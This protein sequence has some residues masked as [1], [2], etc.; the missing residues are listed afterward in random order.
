MANDIDQVDRRILYRLSEDAR[1]ISAPD[2]AE[3]L[4]VS[5]GTIRNR[6]N[7]L[8]EKDIIRGYHASIDYEK[9]GDH[10]V[11]LFACTVEIPERRRIMGEVLEVPGVINVRELMAGQRNLHV[12]AVGEGRE[13]ITKIAH[14]ITNLDVEIEEQYLV[15][16]EASVPFHSFSPDDGTEQE[17]HSFMRLAG[18][19]DVLDLRVQEGAPIADRSLAEAKDADLLADE[20]LVV[21]VEHHGVIETASGATKLRPGDIVTLFSRDGFK[22]EQLSSFYENT[23]EL[24]LEDR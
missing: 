10:L 12:R 15:G 11:G 3:E 17:S 16:N 19:T 4:D 13:D 2:M 6:I 1:G 9:I 14:Q 5:A 23:V 21:A 22:E 18:R 24:D 8:E 20:I 7:K